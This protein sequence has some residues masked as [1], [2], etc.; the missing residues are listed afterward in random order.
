MFDHSLKILKKKMKDLGTYISFY[1][2]YPQHTCYFKATQTYFVGIQ[3]K[4]YSKM[5][6]LYIKILWGK[7]LLRSV[8]K[9]NV[10]Y[11]NYA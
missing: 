4:F 3:D 1:L 10:K 8:K 11:A 7:M 9:K 5:V 2:Y 6:A